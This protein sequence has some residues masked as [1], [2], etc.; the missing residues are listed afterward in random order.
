MAGY[1]IGIDFGTT[2]SVMSVYNAE[3]KSTEPL[4]DKNTNLP[5]PSVIWYRPDGRKIVGA[6][7][8]KNLMGFSNVEGNLFQYSVKRK[9]GSASTIN[10]F[11][12]NVD[13]YEVA[14][15]IFKYLYTD[16]TS[17]NLNYS[18]DEAVVTIPVYFDGRARKDI[19]KAADMAGIYIK[20]FVHEPFAA[21]VGYCTRDGKGLQVE[22]LENQIILVF[23]WGGGTLDITIAQ[24]TKDGIMELSISGL[25]DIAGDFF[26][27]KL[28][29]YSKSIFMDKYRIPREQ[30][31]I[32][33]SNLDRL[34][35]ECERAKISISSENSETIRVA[36]LLKLA[37]EFYDID[38]PLDR[39]IFNN[40]INNEVESAIFQI[41]KALEVA[42]ITSQEI[43]LVL[44]IGGS[45]RIP[46]VRHKLRE[47]FGYR[48]VEIPN[49]NTI[50]SEGAAIIDAEGLQP[51]LS[52]PF[53]VELSDNSLYE[54]FPAGI[55]A[56]KNICHKAVNFYCTDNRDGQAKLILKEL[57]GRT[58]SSR[59]LMKN[60][61]NIP[62]NQELPTPYNHERVSVDFALDED[63]ILHVAGKGATQE[64]GA[65]C[66]IFDLCFGLRLEE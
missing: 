22:N 17:R 66:Q 1:G 60:F 9:L 23:D 8:K 54:V 53:N 2:N 4:T 37:E 36:S 40:L 21:I 32:S 14:S 39:D 26:D 43:D 58:N 63:M 64:N 15:E 5:H 50:I 3:L 6:E 33:P 28:I 44:L 42:N 65:K 56:D 27:E 57:A 11:G 49:A 38:E 48:I 55:I 62:V 35:T 29:K 16:A 18:F 20:N 31:N 7:A 34:R 24:V 30:C 12:R 46:F 41:N 47:I 10:V 52:R 45:S 61:L 51:V 19:R 59:P 25:E 13:V